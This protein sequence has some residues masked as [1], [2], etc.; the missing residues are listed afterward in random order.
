VPT[1]QLDPRI[2]QNAPLTLTPVQGDNSV[3][4]EH[5]YEQIGV[6]LNHV[7]ELE[8]EVERL[9]TKSTIDD[10]KAAMLQPFAEKVFGFVAF[11]CFGVF[12]LLC[13]SGQQGGSFRLSDTVLGI[14]A[15]S[16]AVSVIGL[17]GMVITGLFSSRAK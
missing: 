13:A 15:G 5:A 7:A 16:T 14:V 17:I 3:E 10:V 8:A 6:L 11:Y 1:P 9:E 12:I 4:L 2:I